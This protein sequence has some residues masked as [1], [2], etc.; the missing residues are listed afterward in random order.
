VYRL[1][2]E[3]EVLDLGLEESD[4]VTVVEWGDVAASLLPADHLEVLLE[5]SDELELER[6]VTC[7]PC[8]ASWGPRAVALAAVV[9]TGP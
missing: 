5:P 6:T 4:G 8:G 1:D 2:R 7:T 3:Q 9:G